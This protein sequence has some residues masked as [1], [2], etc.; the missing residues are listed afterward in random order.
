MKKIYLIIL[1]TILFWISFSQKVFAETANIPLTQDTYIQSGYINNNLSDQN[2][3]FVGYDD[4]YGGHRTRTYLQFDMLAIRALIQNDTGRLLSAKINL[5]QNESQANNT[6]LIKMYE[7]SKE[8]DETLVTWKNQPLTQNLIK[9]QPISN[10]IEWKEIDITEWL[11]NIINGQ[12]T[13]FGIAIVA[14]DEVSPGGLFCSATYSTIAQNNGCNDD[15]KPYILLEYEPNYPPIPGEITS[16]EN[17]YST[18]KHLIEFEWTAGSDNNG[19]EITDYIEISLSP[20]FHYKIYESPIYNNEPHLIEL[21]E[22]T[23]Y[24][25]RIKYFD[26]TFSSYSNIVEIEIKNTAPNAGNI[27]NP[28]NESIIKDNIIDFEWQNG[29]DLEEDIVTNTLIVSTNPDFSDH[30]I[31]E[32]LQQLTG[33][34]TEL[35]NGTYYAKIR[36][37]DGHEATYSPTINFTIQTLPTTVLENSDPLLLQPETTTQKPQTEIPPSI[38][39]TPL[40][41]PIISLR[42][43]TTNEVILQVKAQPYT[44]LII[45]LSGKLLPPI[46]LSEQISEVKIAHNFIPG[47][48]YQLFAYLKEN[49]IYSKPS[50]SIKLYLPLTSEIGIGTGDENSKNHIKTDNGKCYLEIHLDQN[51]IS[52]LKCSIPSPTINKIT[53]SENYNKFID[54]SINGS[55]FSN[56][57]IEIN[58]LKCKKY[59]WFIPKFLQKCRNEVVETEKIV[60]SSPRRSL[61]LIDFNTGQIEWGLVS[62]GPATGGNIYQY[63]HLLKAESKSKKLQVA[64]FILIEFK[65]TKYNK[66]FSYYI[67]SNKSNSFTIPETKRLETVPDSNNQYFD[68]VLDHYPIV[69]QWH[70][71]TAFRKDHSGIDFGVKLQKVFAP[72]DGTVRYAQWNT[73]DGE[74][75]QGGNTIR[76]EHPNGM[77]SVYFHLDNYLNKDEKELKVGDKVNKGDL[78]GLSG[79]TGYYNCKPLGYHLHFELR[80]TKDRATHVNPVPYV[81]T[82]WTKI[83]TVANSKNALTGDNPHPT[84]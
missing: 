21:Q 38:S 73:Y 19:E 37:F 65:P 50:E 22:H 66:W 5:Y 52:E 59:P 42:S 79:N 58:Y 35:N 81:N 33:Y 16:P 53:A 7:I 80:K 82:D 51:T 44:Q 60:I 27:I 14:T 2:I 8:W 24:Y 74:C 9:I 18:N 36:Y 61:R 11:I 34:H 15:Y 70:G 13:E 1:L 12:S 64:N 49:N 31:I 84:Y 30:V 10:K 78:I 72:A 62:F 75:Y 6:Y 46:N 4:K 56:I 45:N 43:I 68:F 28:L 25:A 41:T 39:N 76:I 67:L 40:Q 3:I 63:K 26:G 47:I 77:Y 71:D 55:M 20:E 54:L 23:T 57:E 17:K 69:T 29:N 32:E 48:E 83:K